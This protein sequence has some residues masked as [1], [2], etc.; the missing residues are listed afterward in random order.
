[1]KIRSIHECVPNITLADTRICR[2]ATSSSNRKGISRIII[3]QS[4][5]VFFFLFTRT[6]PAAYK[7]RTTEMGSIYKLQSS[8]ISTALFPF[9]RKKKKTTGRFWR[10]LAQFV[11]P[12][13]NLELTNRWRL[14]PFSAGLSKGST[15]NWIFLLVSSHY[16]YNISR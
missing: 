4:S 9:P 5:G 16:M 6:C 14:L 1:M 3:I 15:L 12:S 13:T 2:L 7:K 10:E 8:R 11:S